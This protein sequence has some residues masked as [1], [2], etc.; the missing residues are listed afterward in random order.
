MEDCRT[1]IDLL[2]RRVALDRERPALQYKHQGHFATWTWS[3]LQRAV[4][5]TA[6]RLLEQ[7]VAVGDRVAQIS[8]N[9]VEWILVD[10]A[11]Q[12][13]GAI[14]VPMHAPLTGPQLAQQLNDCEPRVVFLSSDAQVDK[15]ADTAHEVPCSPSYL[16]FDADI[17]TANRMSCQAF[18][19]STDELP[20]H[21]AEKVAQRATHI[22]PRSVATILYTSGTTGTPR[23][24]VLTQANITSNAL[25]ASSAFKYGQSDRRINFLPL[26]HIFAR[27]CDLYTWLA[28]GNQLILAESRETIVADC[29]ATQPTVLNGVPY[30]FDKIYRSLCEQGL[31]RQTGVVRALL[32][33][34]IRFCCSG[35]AP[36]PVHLFDFYLEQDVPVLEGYG[37]TET[38]PVI[39]MST[40]QFA[41]RGAAGKAI[42]GV[43]IKIAEDGEIL[44]RGPHVMQG[45]YQRPAETEKIIRDGWLCTGDL[46][47]LDT[48][49]FLFVTGRKKELIVTAG[50]KNI[51]PASLEALLTQDPL[52]MQAMVVGNRRNYL[53]ALIVPDIAALQQHLHSQGQRFDDDQTLQ[54]AEV[55]NLFEAIVHKR[56]QTV[57]HHE[58]VC[59]FTLLAQP[60]TIAR[61]ELTAKLSL[62]RGQI[63]DHHAAAIEA[64]YQRS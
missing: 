50:G 52:V 45:Y 32:G 61:G 49:G 8:E 26:S 11:T 53:T 33:G 2:Q 16:V 55:I 59:T 58:Q 22:T 4:L 54:N 14:H 12:L 40:E 62:R 51:A 43:D 10:L 15:L 29:Q 3:E 44:T 9:R 37:L 23:G 63:M 7:G 18:T 6:N 41:K 38:S 24:V 31:Q 64:M 34:A 39:T 1:I 36:L 13:V 28:V 17:P 35:G 42:D 60:F 21:R 48:D 19:V 47:H 25:A 46:G 30:F 57:S 20:D 27:T 5:Q 56:L